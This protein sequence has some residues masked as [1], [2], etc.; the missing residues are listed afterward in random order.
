[1]VASK[2]NLE[3]RVIQQKVSLNKPRREADFLLFYGNQQILCYTSLATPAY[4]INQSIKKHILHTL[5]EPSGDVTYSRG[6]VIA[7]SSLPA[8]AVGR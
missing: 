5:V 2:N 7:S 3:N 4:S 1:M 6:H 8:R